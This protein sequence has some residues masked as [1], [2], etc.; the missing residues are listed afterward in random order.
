MAAIAIGAV[1]A[2]V[3]YG[4]MIFK[5][6]RGFDDSLDVMAV[7]GVGG[8]WGALATGIFASL[9]VNSAGA[10]GLLSG[11]VELFLKQALGVAVTAGFAFG[12][13]FIIAK[14]VDKLVGL[15]VKEPEELIGLD[16]AQHAERAYGG[17]VR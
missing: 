16:I 10:D 4:A 2:L 5:I 13:S 9:A 11:N 14:V 17:S 6:K 15:R 7:H 12:G 3:C 1:A 8:I